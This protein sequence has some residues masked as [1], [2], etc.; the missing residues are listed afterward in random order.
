MQIAATGVNFMDT[1]A[2]RFGAAGL[3]LSFIPGVE[4]AGRV[5]ALGEGVTEF[6]AGDR[7]AW[8]YAY[9]SYAEQV[10]VPVA[11]AVPVP[12]AIS[13]EI[14]ASVMMQGLS[15][16]HFATEAYPVQPGDVAVVHAAAGGVGRLV[17]QPP[18]HC[19]PGVAALARDLGRAGWGGR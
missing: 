8:V 5:T 9:G 6:A 7:V 16:H 3:G 14:A 11:S 19:T 12:A 17:T 2:R 18:S 10:A 1:G 4:A 15:A 13:D